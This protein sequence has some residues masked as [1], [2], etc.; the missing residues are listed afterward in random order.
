MILVALLVLGGLAGMFLLGGS[1]IDRR[2]DASVIGIDA[3]EPWLKAQGLAVERSNPRIRPDIAAL[4]LRI[5]PLYDTD[6]DVEAAEPADARAAYYA[7]TLRDIHRSDLLNRT[8]NLPALVVL[9][10]WVGGTVVSSVA[11]KSAQIPEAE[12]QRLTRQIGLGA[13][14]PIRPQDGLMTANTPEGEL[15]LFQ[16]QLFDAARLPDICRPALAVPQGVLVATCRWPDSGTDLHV[17]ADPDLMNNHGL[18]LGDNAMI[19]T[20]LLKTLITPLP[21]DTGK[22]QQGQ[23]AESPAPQTN[24]RIYIDT[25]G[26]DLVT[27]YDYT[28]ERQDYDRSPEDFARFFAPPL[29]G[30]WAMLLIVLGI[31][32]WR[33]ALRFGPV[34]A[35]AIDTP[36]HSKTTAIE[37]NAR[38]LRIAGHD[39]HLAAD[40]VQASLADLAQ[41]TFGRGPGSGVQGIE[42]LLTHLER[43]DPTTTRALRLAAAQLA[44]PA[45]TARPQDLRHHLETFRH[46]LEKLTHVH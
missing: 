13:L 40:Y 33:G 11:H 17:L 37:T 15:V 44:D 9:P 1:R 38:L 5:L 2:L 25:A 42:R 34:R 20:G 22:N 46:L 8:Y 14:R 24:S 26:E 3:L 6:L 19:L 45:R 18:T 30:L 7:T 27:Y 32:L 39:S 16:P 43:R 29:A 28:D 21:Q 35:A 10:K 36:E 4:N 41:S 12:L 23:R 31:A